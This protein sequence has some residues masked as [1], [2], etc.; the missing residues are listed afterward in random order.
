VIR[1]AV[2]GVN[3]IGHLHCQQYMQNEKVKLVAVCDLIQ[4]RADKAAEQYKVKAYSNLKE[5]LRHEAVDLVSVATAG[6]ENGSHHYEPT[7]IAIEAGKDVLVEKPIS[8]HIIEA[9]EMVKAAKDKG[10]RLACNLNHRFTPAA[11]KGKSLIEEQKL[12]QLLFIN[13]KLTTGNSKEGTP[14][15]QLRALQPHSL[16]VMRYFGG[17][18]ARVQ[19]FMTQ[20]PGRSLWSTSSINLQFSSGAVGHLTGS[21]DM[22]NR[23]P[24][25]YC[26]VA[27]H[28]G[29]FEIDNVYERFC[30]YPHES[31]EQMV[32]RNS[33]LT[34][35]KGFNET[36][37][38][39]INHF[40]DEIDKAI[41]PE[42]IA[43]SGADALAV[44]EVIEAAIL[45]HQENGAVIDVNNHEKGEMA[46][47]H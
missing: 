14:W 20:A 39:R 43:G 36:F 4:E 32:L 47:E 21:Y 10:I 11:H 40:I 41:A 28:Q 17:D 31:D 15:F 5:L 42:A 24:I 44:Q 18:I 38:Y 30:Y 19:A 6:V 26:E 25:E 16:D 29:R 1:A 22:S 45:S 7:M 34:G 23:H 3:N 46:N 37:K 35:F 12:G 8:N 13:M 27:G 2:V 33:I 9:R